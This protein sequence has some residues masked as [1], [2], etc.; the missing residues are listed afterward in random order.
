M[1]TAKSRSH[2]AL[3]QESGMRGFLRAAAIAASSAHRTIF[4]RGRR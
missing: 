2:N 3:K 1:G 4:R